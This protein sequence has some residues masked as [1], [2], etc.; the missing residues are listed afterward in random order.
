MARPGGCSC[1][2][3]EKMLIFI[4]EWGDVVKP[5]LGGIG[6]GYLEERL[7]PGILITSFTHSLRVFLCKLYEKVKL[8][9][10][11]SVLF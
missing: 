1:P 2:R 3:H 8:Q 11:I 7:F 10:G 9:R 6:A 4:K 5:A